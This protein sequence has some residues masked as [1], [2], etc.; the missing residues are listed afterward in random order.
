MDKMDREE[1][2]SFYNGKKV[3]ITGHTGF[4]GSWLS[5][6][7]NSLG[8]EVH[9]YA[10]NPPTNPSMYEI[11]NVNSVVNSNIADIR[12]FDSLNKCVQRIQPEIIFHMAAQPLVIDSYK[13]PRETY[14]VNVMGSVNLLD[15]VRN[16]KAVKALVNITTDKCYE[17]LEQEIGYVETDRLGG[18]DPYS[19][20][21]ACSELVTTSFRDSFFSNNDSTSIATA[22]AGNVIGGGDWASNRLIPDFIRAVVSN[23]TLKIRFPKAVRP[24]QHVLEPLTGYLLL[25]KKLYEKP[26]EFSGSWNFGPD[27][28]EVY[29]VETIVKKLSETWGLEGVY[30]LEPNDYHETNFLKLNCDKA[31]S[32]LGWKPALDIDSSLKMIVDWTKSFIDSEDMKKV[33]EEQIE[34]YSN[35]LN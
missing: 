11:A 33:T 2:K 18:H 19:N 13:N 7:L 8:A 24:W 6:F 15:A 20:S 3:L 27:E 9:G 17:N 28:E 25:A 26:N 1:L 21:K 31:K 22:R 23:D 29:S 30:N 34:F 5:L 10:L 32:E 14:E 35:K 12:D 4:K 16:C